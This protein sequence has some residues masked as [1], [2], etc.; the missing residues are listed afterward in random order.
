MT[1]TKDRLEHRPEPRIYI[2]RIGD[3]EYKLEQRDLHVHDD[4]ALWHSNPRLLQVPRPAGGTFESQEELEAALRQTK[5]Y[6]NLARSINELGQM[7]PIYVW[8]REGMEKYLVLE[9]ATR[10]TVLRELDRKQQSDPAKRKRTMVKAKILPPDFDDRERAILLA[11]IHV[12]GSGVRSWAR[13]VQAKFIYENVHHGKGVMSAQEMADA[14]GKSAS[15]VSRL[16]AAYEF[17]SRF[18]DHVDQDDAEQLAVQEFSTL[19]EISKAPEVG[20]ML[21][22]Y[23]NSDRDPLRADVFDMVRNEVFKEYRDAR[24]MREFY[25]DPE[26]WAQLKSGERHI[27][28]TLAADVKTNSSSLKAS[29]GGLETKVERAIGRDPEHAVNEED[30]EHLRRALKLVEDHLHPEV[31]PIRREMVRF[32]GVLEDASLSDIRSVDPDELKRLGIAYDHLQ[33][34]FGKHNSQ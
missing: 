18:M 9:G 21:K 4:V 5:G 31:R 17:A 30:L 26:K 10:L 27:A 25:R 1:K 13:Y 8:K 29:I 6:N 23:D 33:E 16:Q 22:D 11:G 12:R 32:A 20:P 15:W 3:K 2:E 7:E 28:N 14:M 19:E 24:F 34:Q